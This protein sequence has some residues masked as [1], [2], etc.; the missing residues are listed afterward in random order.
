M[1]RAD[2]IRAIKAGTYRNNQGK[3]KKAFTSSP[4]SSE[5]SSGGES[6]ALPPIKN[7]AR[8]SAK[9]L[10]KMEQDGAFALLDKAF[11]A[12]IWDVS[13]HICQCGCNKPIPEP[14]STA[15]FHHLLEKADYPLLRHIPENI[16]ILTEEC[17]TA[18]TSN[19]DNRPKVRKRRE[20]VFKLL[21]G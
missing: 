10:A 19:I 9:Q 13:P 2:N 8:L 12:T 5:E 14:W 4:A 17:H 7:G 21:I 11:Y 20:Q 1:D 18:V 6:L 3:G 15:N 16:M